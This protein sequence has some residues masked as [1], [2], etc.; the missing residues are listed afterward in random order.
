MAEMTPEMGNG[1]GGRKLVDVAREKMR[2]RHMAYRT[3]QVCP[4]WICRYTAFH[5]RP[6]PRDLG[7]VEVE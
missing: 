3:E 6:H 5:K 7:A 1:S 4:Q 2:T